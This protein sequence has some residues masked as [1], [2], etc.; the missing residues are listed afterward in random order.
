MIASIILFIH[1][2]GLISL[3]SA[4]TSLFIAGIVLIIA[5]VGIVSFGLLAVNGLLA[6]YA[7]YSLYNQDSAL[8]FNAGW[9]LFFGVVFTEAVII[10]AFII[11][12]KR[13]R[14]IKNTTGT[15]NMIGQKASIIDWD[16]QKGNV[17]FEGEIWK[18]NSN[19]E[20]ELNEN[21][22]VTIES[23]NKLNLTITA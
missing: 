20:L 4:Y 16:S 10:I 19:T 13:I 8:A 12:M 5:E 21:D 22:E 6:L 17:R 2:M 11:V 15:E 3:E 14:R 7:S 23:V 18:A 1:Y 9:P